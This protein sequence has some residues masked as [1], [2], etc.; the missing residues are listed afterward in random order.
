MYKYDRPILSLLMESI[1]KIERYTDSF[2][3]ASDFVADSKAFDAT[4]MNFI[5]IAECVGRLSEYF[6]ASHPEIEWQKIYSFRNL[7]AHDYFGIDE[8][9][10]WDIV[11]NH[12]PD[13]KSKIKNII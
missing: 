12:L 2:A 13:L 3:N 11:N 8:D 7:I 6:K 5:A 9:E 4:L 10:V 1:E